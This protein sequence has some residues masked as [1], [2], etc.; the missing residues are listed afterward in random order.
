MVPPHT[1]FV[2][3]NFHRIFN[4]KNMPI[5]SCPSSRSS[6]QPGLPS[7]AIGSIC[8]ARQILLGVPSGFETQI[9]S[10]WKILQCLSFMDV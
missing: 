9:F 1:S 5:H 4:V 2:C 3:V 6:T 7:F 10:V 8:R